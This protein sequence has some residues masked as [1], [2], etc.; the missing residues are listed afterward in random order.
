MLYSLLVDHS[1]KQKKAK[2][3]DKDYFERINHNK[4]KDLLLNNKCLKHSMNRTQSKSRKQEN[5]N[6]K[7]TKVI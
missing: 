3:M 2:G 1:N 7:E 4:Y 5:R 6:L